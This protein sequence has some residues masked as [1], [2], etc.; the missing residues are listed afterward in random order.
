MQAAIARLAAG[1]TTLLIAHRLPPTLRADRIVVL[2]DGRIV[3]EG[4]P[5]ELLRRAEG[6][7]QRLIR[8]WRGALSPPL[9]EA[10]AV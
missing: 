3:E 1:R 10:R 5:S 6:R 9:V 8:L 2:E 7:Y 4:P